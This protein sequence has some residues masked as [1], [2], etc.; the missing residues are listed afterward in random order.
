MRI[1]KEKQSFNQWWLYVVVAITAVGWITLL[2]NKINKETNLPELV[3][4]LFMTLL[5]ILFCGGI[6]LLRLKT[7]IDPYGVTASFGPFPFFTKH[8]S[9]KEIKEIFVRQYSPIA[10]YGGWGIRSLG[11][12]KAYNVSGNYG[13]QIVTRKG[14]KFLIGTNQPQVV[15]KVLRY[16]SQR[17][18]EQKM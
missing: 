14:K 18:K 10:E 8:F 17:Q 7:K 12:A 13:I 5:L 9:W 2:S 1:F 11:K 6:F 3:L 4:Y 15:E 16:Y